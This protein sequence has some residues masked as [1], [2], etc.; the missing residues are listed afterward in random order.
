MQSGERGLTDQRDHEVLLTLM[1]Q[2]GSVFHFSEHA[3]F[4]GERSKNSA[5]AYVEELN[6]LDPGWVTGAI[7]KPP[8]DA[9]LIRAGGIMDRGSMRRSLAELPGNRFPIQR[10]R[11]TSSSR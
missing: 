7:Y 8:N 11:K 4:D 2:F 10:I 6:V 9:D 5:P 3:I 1:H